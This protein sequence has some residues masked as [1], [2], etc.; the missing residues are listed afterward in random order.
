MSLALAPRPAPPRSVDARPVL[1]LVAEPLGEVL[2]PAGTRPVLR[3][4]P[5]DAEVDLS[6]ARLT[7][8][9]VVAPST[10]GAAGGGPQRPSGSARGGR[11]VH[12]TRRGRLM[13]LALLVLFVL[14]AFSLGRVSGSVAVAG[15]VAPAPAHETV[16]VQAGD[17]LW[18]LARDVAPGRDPRP[19]VEALQ[20][21]NGLEGAGLAAG[22]TLLVPASR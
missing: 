22:Q 3:L 8:M 16:V 15:D 11:S 10:A 1:R 6:R 14:A 5:M 20:R 17:T 13:V 7:P 19:V 4:L 12:L 2:V 18:S 9:E 21:L